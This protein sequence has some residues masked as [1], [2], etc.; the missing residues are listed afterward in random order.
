[1]W[2]SQDWRSGKF[3]YVFGVI[4][5]KLFTISYSSTAKPFIRTCFVN[6]WTVGRKQSPSSGQF[7]PIAMELC[8][9]RTTPGTH[10]CAVTRHKL[11]EL[12]WKVPTH[13]SYDPCYSM[14]YF[15]AI[16]DYILCLELTR[17]QNF[18]HIFISSI[19][20]NTH[21]TLNIDLIIDVGSPTE[22]I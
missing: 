11:R 19:R 3:F 10:T 4:G 22:S 20:K 1:M 12:D 17:K 6:K 2:S 21:F 16:L 15:L 18:F 7:W 5:G 14:Q 8:S 13:P 9:I